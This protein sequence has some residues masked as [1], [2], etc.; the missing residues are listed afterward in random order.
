MISRGSV[1]V[2][3]KS[4][5]NC[6]NKASNYVSPQM[7][8]C[9]EIVFYASGSGKTLIG[10][11]L[12][13]YSAGD[14]AIIEPGTVHDELCITE[15]EIHFCL[16]TYE[17]ILHLENG[18]HSL[19]RLENGEDII[20]HITDLFH[21]IQNEMYYKQLSY[22]AVLDFLMGELLVAVCRT[23]SRVRPTSDG[24]EYIKMYIKENYTRRL[25]F[26][27]LANHV[28]Y[29][30][31]RLRHIFKDKVGIS[32]SRYLLNVRI[33]RAKEL[34]V[35]TD[36]SI[37]H[38]AKIT[39]FGGASRFVEVFRQEIGQTPGRYRALNRDNDVMQIL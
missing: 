32:P 14:I 22:E 23:H 16:F 2:E 34:L 3:L 12:Y 25:D 9:Y 19:C 5:I 8:S 30:Y 39:G 24:I 21:R 28:G 7:H 17:G 15:S 27:I 13:D 10:E 36:Q 33:R 6:V 29:S 38:I 37:E 20:A 31:D 4:Y 35:E 1:Q 11:D 26:H 18:V